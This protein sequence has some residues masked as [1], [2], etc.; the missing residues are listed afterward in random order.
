VCV[1]VLQSVH[2]LIL[3]RTACDSCLIAAQLTSPGDS[4]D[5]GSEETGEDEGRNGVGYL[6]GNYRRKNTSWAAGERDAECIFI[7]APLYY[8]GFS[9]PCTGCPSFLSPEPLELVLFAPFRSLCV[10]VNAAPFRRDVAWVPA[11]TPQH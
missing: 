5:L 2:S 6:E 10:N 4:D 8:C 11:A 3:P 9:A 7:T 1:C